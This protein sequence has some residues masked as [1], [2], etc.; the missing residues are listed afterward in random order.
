MINISTQLKQNIEVCKET[1]TI[2]SLKNYSEHGKRGTKPFQQK[3]G[4]NSMHKLYHTHKAVP[5]YAVGI[6]W[7]RGFEREYALQTVTQ[8]QE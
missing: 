6:L 5:S 2:A 8:M 4:K 1:I 3:P 7:N